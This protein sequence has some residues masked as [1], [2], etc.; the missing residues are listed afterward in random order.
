MIRLEAGARTVLAYCTEC[1]SWRELR[2]TRAAALTA[3]AHHALVV[4]DQAKR[5]NTFRELAARL[6][7]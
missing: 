4:H 1:P 6:R 5:A 7:A 3:A 2:P